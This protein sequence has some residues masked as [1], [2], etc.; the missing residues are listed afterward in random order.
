LIEEFAAA[1][2][3]VQDIDDDASVNQTACDQLSGSGIPLNSLHAS[4]RFLA[5]S[6][7]PFISALRKFRM[8]ALL[9]G[10]GCIPKGLALTVPP[11]LAL[12]HVHHKGRSLPG[13]SDLVDG[14]GERGW[15]R[16]ERPGA[17]HVA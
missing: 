3:A 4:D 2:F 14:G 6:T 17:S 10:A 15:N 13:A 7:N 12:E 1:A 8:I 5:H 9:P 16:D 11:Y